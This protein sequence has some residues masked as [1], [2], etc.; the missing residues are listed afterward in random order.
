MLAAEAGGYKRGHLTQGRER[1]VVLFIALIALVALAIAG[2]AVV[3][4]V[5]TGNLISGNMAFRQ[6]A[7]QTSDIG[8]EA[9]YIALPTI[10]ATSKDANIANQYFALRQPVDSIGMPTTIIW[11]NVA[12]RDNSNAVV[13]CSTQDYQVKYII[14]RLCE[15]QTTGSTMIT[16]VQTYCL[17]DVTTAKG[18][19]KGAFGAVFS[20]ADSVYYRVTVQVTGPRNT[21]SNVQVLIS[22]N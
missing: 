20:S 16:D 7:L 4:S 21:N 18:G 1:G 12:C 14:E 9:A 3:R 6:A 5:D 11:A 22:K 17:T 8:I 10:L 15:E 13:T 2:L 19:S